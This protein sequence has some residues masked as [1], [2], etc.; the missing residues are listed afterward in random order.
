MHATSAI[1]KSL[2][3][4]QVSL[5]TFLATVDAVLVSRLLQERLEDSGMLVV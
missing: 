4:M 5:C 1:E 3:D 2:L